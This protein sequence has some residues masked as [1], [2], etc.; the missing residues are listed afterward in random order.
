MTDDE[1]FRTQIQPML[2]PGEQVLH[3]AY[4]VR[5]PGLMMQ[6]L[7][8]G[9]LLLWM[10]TKAYYA[11]LTNRRLILVRSKMRAW[12]PGPKQLNL[13][14][15]EYPV[16]MMTHAT[17]GGI[18]N[19]RSITFHFQ[20]GRSETLRIS[21]WFKRIPGTK[22]FWEQ[23]P[24]LISSGQL[25]QQAALPL[26]PAPLPQAHVVGGAPQYA[27][28]GPQHQA[29]YQPQPQLGFAPGSHVVV[30]AQDGNRYPATVA[31]ASDGQV[32]CQMPDGRQYWFPLQ[33]VAPA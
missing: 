15:E 21:P 22:M 3:T 2:A 18:A 31:Q 9:G 1:Y 10:I 16:A 11:V 14:V 19:N 32:L 24:G 13:G 33:A 26:P 29:P 28:G 6:M 12:V 20:G 8:V 17:T 25:Q 30:M 23:V 5:Q 4:M 27:P 7:L